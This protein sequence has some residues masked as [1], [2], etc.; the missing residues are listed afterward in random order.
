[1]NLDYKFVNARH[2]REFV[3]RLY[4]A[5]GLNGQD[6]AIVADVL[7]AAD[8]RGVDS[9]GVSRL[10]WYDE[11]IEKGLI[12]L[13]PDMAVVNEAKTTAL[14]DGD[15]GLG[16]IVGKYAMNI[17]IDKAR[18]Y[19]SG[20]AAVRRSNHY[21]IA[22]YYSMMALQEN[23]IGISMTNM[24]PIVA[25]LYGKEK[26]LGTNPI[27]F[28][29]PA[30]KEEPFI[31]DMATTGVSGGKLEIAT[32]EE[33][34]IPLG[35]AIDKDGAPSTDPR[36]LWNGGALLPLGGDYEHGG[37]KG[38]GLATLVNALC[39]ALSGSIYGINK[40]DSKLFGQP[41]SV[42]ADVGHFFGAIRIDGFREKQDILDSMDQ[43]LSHFK[44]S[45]PAPGHNKVYVAG[46]RE[47]EA[48]RT[49]SIQGIPLH[50]KT[51][52][53][54]LSLARKHRVDPPHFYDKETN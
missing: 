6:A 29:I 5:Y 51:V 19:G 9:H 44:T 8:L 25:P 41:L 18:A 37:H 39:G 12:N 35:L 10:H 38:Y 36:S 49:R 34:D 22:G 53:Q 47:Y 42:T 21:G 20:F 33:R 52:D 45:E 16:M 4:G 50:V 2:L 17:A 1:M 26:L 28:A 30:D 13:T 43:M 32:R 40:E 23:M 24:I 31:L 27:S 14:V 7:L 11:W 3:E 46:E 15:N 54:I 48:E